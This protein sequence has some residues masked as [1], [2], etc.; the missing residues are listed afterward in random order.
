MTDLRMVITFSEQYDE[1]TNL[2]ISEDEDQPHLQKSTPG[3][4][5]RVKVFPNMGSSKGPSSSFEEYAR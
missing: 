1:V 5:C 3:T 4:A 2:H